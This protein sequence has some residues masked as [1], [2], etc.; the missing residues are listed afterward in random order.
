[1]HHRLTSCNS[2]WR[3]GNCS[4]KKWDLSKKSYAASFYITYEIDV[5]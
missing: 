4:P 2:S 1:M 5:T 3:W